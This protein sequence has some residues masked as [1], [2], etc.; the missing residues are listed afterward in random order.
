MERRNFCRST[1][2]IT[3]GI[4]ALAGSS[5]FPLRADDHELESVRV[6]AAK[7]EIYVSTVEHFL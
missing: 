5:L 2:G 6:R 4:G 1:A 7:G 3:V